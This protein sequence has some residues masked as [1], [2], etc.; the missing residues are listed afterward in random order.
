MHKG[1]GSISYCT[2]QKTWHRRHSTFERHCV[3]FQYLVI[4]DSAQ[5][6][7]VLACKPS[8]CWHYHDTSCQESK[9][10]PRPELQNYNAE[11]MV[12]F[13]II[14]HINICHLLPPSLPV[15]EPFI[16]KGWAR[17]GPTAQCSR[18]K[19]RHKTSSLLFTLLKHGTMT[20]LFVTSIGHKE[21]GMQDCLPLLLSINSGARRE[22]GR[23]G[24]TQCLTPEWTKHCKTSHPTL[25]VSPPLLSSKNVTRC[26]KN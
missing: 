15:T 6:A 24:G 7:A 12:R 20:R 14:L 21:A 19:T 22:G 26:N 1:S 17:A 11:I 13:K 9:R 10:R 23:E 3:E 25:S 5:S 2:K 4:S 18:N 16:G 8:K